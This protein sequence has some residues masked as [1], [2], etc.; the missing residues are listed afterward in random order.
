[1]KLM[2]TEL[3][4]TIKADSAADA[5]AEL[6]QIGVR[7]AK[8]LGVAPT[9]A[10]TRTEPPLETPAKGNGADELAPAKR[11]RKRA[12]VEPD[13]ATQ[14]G[15]D[16]TTIIKGLT[17]IF[18]RGEPAIR[19]RITAFRDGHGVQRLRELKDD[20]LAGAAAL[21]AELQNDSAP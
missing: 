8:E 3:H 4:L 5:L 16:R 9:P 11:T 20:A 15:F 19:E 13:V 7:A 18:M 12:A 2:T 14:T 21:L 1:M 10:Y 17:E 6:A